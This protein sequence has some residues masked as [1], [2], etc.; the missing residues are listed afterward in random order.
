MNPL[1]S[2]KI[3]SGSLHRLLTR[4]GA[5]Y[6]PNRSNSVRHI[7]YSRRLRRWIAVSNAGGGYLL[8][9]EYAECPCGASA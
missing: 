4:H 6:Y 3:H 5:Q 1:S 8:V 7:Y 9:N 2:K